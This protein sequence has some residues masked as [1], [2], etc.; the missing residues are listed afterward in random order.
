MPDFLL[1]IGTEEIPARMIDAASLELRER[2]NKLLERERLPA[3]GPITY[4]DTPRRLA[5][6][7]RRDGRIEAERGLI[8]ISEAF[9][10]HA[11]SRFAIANP[12]HAPY[13][14]RAREAL[15]KSGLW[16]PMQSGLVLAEN[17]A[18]A[19]QYVVT[20]AAEAGITA[21]PLVKTGPTATAL[22]FSVVPAELHTP[23]R[24][25]MVL[26]KRASPAARAP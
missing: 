22:R 8:A 17:V 11:L 1:E 4:V 19:A 13:G 20:G 12:E 18:Q 23:L 7:A 21:L 25:R 2:V 10:G 15:E 24:Q 5:V 16:G 14:A 9:A 3:T 6:I 26:T